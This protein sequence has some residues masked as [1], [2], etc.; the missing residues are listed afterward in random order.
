MCVRSEKV[1]NY[2]SNQPAPGSW[3]LY[4]NL[5]FT[6]RE[7]RNQKSLAGFETRLGTFVRETTRC[8]EEQST[9]AVLSRCE[10]RQVTCRSCRYTTHYN[11]HE[12]QGLDGTTCLIS[13]EPYKK[14]HY[15]NISYSAREQPV[16]RQDCVLYAK[17][18]SFHDLASFV[19]LRGFKA[20][21]PL[22]PGR[23]PSPQLAFQC[24]KKS[25]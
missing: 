20:V 16:E 4:N 8:L 11:T 5:S 13:P 17:A 1:C 6:M 24:P 14:K 22:L 2:S 12:L 23:I 7:Y 19:H 3:K 18:T 21:P 10:A 25:L 15:E 9:G